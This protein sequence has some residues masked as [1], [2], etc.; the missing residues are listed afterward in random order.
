[1]IRKG[2]SAMTVARPKRRLL[3]LAAALLLS[4]PVTHRAAAEEVRVASGF[5]LSYLPMYVA[6][7]RKLIEAHAAEAG[8]SDVKVVYQH[9]SSG[10]ALTDALISGSA[11]IAMAGVSV[12]LNVWD[13]TVGRSVVKGM[14]AICDSPIVFNTIDP[15]IQ[16]IRDLGDGDRVAMAAGRGTQHALVFEMATVKEFGW[17]QRRKFEALAVSMAHA[18]G[19]AALISGGAVVKTHVTTVPFIQ[20]ELANPK[21][22]TI[23]N[24]YDVV[25]GRHTLISAYAYEKWRTQN[26][27]LYTATFKALVQAMDIIAADKRA[28]AELFARVEPSKLTVEEIHKML[29]DENMLTFSPTPRKVMAFADYMHKAG[30]MKNQLGSWKEAFFD[31]VHDLQGD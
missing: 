5:G 13:K 28:A 1:M 29:L 3:S 10:P 4:L 20:M 21:V 7:E 24:S 25:G 16:S 9:L 15:R 6:V 8:L 17:D 12:M 11:D 31:N 18:D 27:K 26:P 23:L 14:M 2:I 30:Y 19:V 22:R